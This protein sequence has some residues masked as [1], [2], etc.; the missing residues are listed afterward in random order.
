LPNR[1]KEIGQVSDNGLE[2]SP[3]LITRDAFRI[4]SLV[5]RIITDVFKKLDKKLEISISV[6]WLFLE[7][8]G[9]T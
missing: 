9:L 7:F 2:I 8:L 6:F 5:G 1:S 3:N 4:C